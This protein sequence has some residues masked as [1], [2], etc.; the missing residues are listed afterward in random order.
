ME[1][2]RVNAPKLRDLVQDQIGRLADALGLVRSRMQVEYVLNW[3]GFVNYSF[4]ISDG[5]RGFHLK[6]AADAEQVELLQRVRRLHEILE[7]RYRAPR[8]IDW[9]QIPETSFQGP[10]FE[11]I[12]GRPAQELSP[13]LAESVF[14]VLNRLHGDHELALR[15][16]EE[17]SAR[18]CLDTFLHTYV[19]RFREDL[20]SIAESPP[21]FLHQA[22]VEW[23]REQAV[24][25]ERQAR[26]S[27]AFAEWSRS[28]IH[29]DLW[30]DNLLVAEDGGCY[31][32]D[33]D[34]LA[35][36][37]PALDWATLLGPSARRPWPLDVQL[38]PDAIPRDAGLRERLVLYARASLLDWVI[39]P[40]AD[41]IE[42]ERFPEY[43]E[44]V[45]AEKERVHRAAVASYRELYSSGT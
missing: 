26:A 33:W 39:D 42:A 1:A 27:P 29:G 32:L 22:T 40:L 25:L 37:D 16:A 35:L 43:T 11:L 12:R 17:M 13:S 6:L 2:A 31:L 21:A 20:A 23:M 15:L 10:L 5:A 41:Y 28:P 18:S 34:E 38:V 14:P 44:A 7:R 9:V 24:H 8:M 45:R 36:G 30:L 3:G 19:R 4:R